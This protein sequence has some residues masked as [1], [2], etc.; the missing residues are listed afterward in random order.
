MEL[1]MHAPTRLIMCA[2]IGLAAISLALAQQGQPSQA[3]PP[4]NPTP[5]PQEPTQSPRELLPPSSNPT[6]RQTN[7]D[8]RADPANQQDG[9]RTNQD[10]SRT[11]APANQNNRWATPFAFRNPQD[12]ARF[13]QTATQLSRLEERMSR[14]NEAM[15]KRLGEIRQMSSDRQL[16]VT[17]ELMQ[18]M[19]QSQSELMEY[20]AQ[21]RTAWSGDI[22]PATPANST[23]RPPPAAR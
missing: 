7:P 1:P 6:P 22:S 11:N 13:T 5:R 14:S 19:L 10:G 2:G 9:N 15:L 3:P 21:S 12:E 23:P 16:G 18:Q 20:L 8:N 17:L 4:S